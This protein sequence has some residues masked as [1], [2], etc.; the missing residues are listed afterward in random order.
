M[1]SQSPRGRESLPREQNTGQERRRKACSPGALGQQG[2]QA[3]WSRDLSLAPWR[4]LPRGGHGR[5]IQIPPPIVLGERAERQAALGS[6][7]SFFVET[8]VHTTCTVTG[9]PRTHLLG[10]A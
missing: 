6:G 5:C 8:R 4:A 1:L 10:S 2:G 9:A 7:G 3:P